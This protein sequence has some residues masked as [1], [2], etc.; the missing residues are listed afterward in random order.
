MKRLRKSNQNLRDL[1]DTIKWTNICLM[2][3][4]E[5]EKDKGERILGEKMAQKFPNWMNIN[6]HEE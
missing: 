6:I 5:E 4:S 3:V 2:G 1:W